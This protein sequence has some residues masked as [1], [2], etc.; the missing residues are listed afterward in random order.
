MAELKACRRAA[1]PVGG[2]TACQHEV[3]AQANV[4]GS[5]ARADPPSPRQGSAS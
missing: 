3:T 2:A 5:C 1:D 4:V